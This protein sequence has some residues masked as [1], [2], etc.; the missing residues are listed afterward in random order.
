MEPR[1][2]MSQKDLTAAREKRTRG[3]EASRIVELDRKQRAEYLEL[4]S[5]MRLR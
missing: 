3:V 2:R 4:L 5:E 1:E